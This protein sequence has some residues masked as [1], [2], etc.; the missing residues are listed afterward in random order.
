MNEN[1][2]VNS[3]YKARENL[4]TKIKQFMNSSETIV[5]LKIEDIHYIIKLL[6]DNFTIQAHNIMKEN[7]TMRDIFNFDDLFE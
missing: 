3:G 5:Y 1:D 6:T 2:H 4:H 7:Q